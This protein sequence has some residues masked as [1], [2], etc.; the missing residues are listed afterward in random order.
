MENDYSDCKN[1][2]VTL[3]A[4]RPKEL[5]R[6]EEILKEMAALHRKKN[7]AYGNS[8]SISVEKYGMIAAL[9]RMSDKFNRI[10][11]LI[12]NGAEENDESLRDSLLDMAS[13]AVMSIVELERKEVDDE[14]EMD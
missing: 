11:N 13:Y 12:L 3:I 2:G 8:F 14:D 5:T 1:Y 4:E 10:E 9:T 6:F 7:E